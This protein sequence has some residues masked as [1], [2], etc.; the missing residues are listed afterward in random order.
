MKIALASDHAGFELKKGILRYFE[1][2]SV[3]I[4]DCG[5]YD[6]NPVDYVDT[7]VVACEK[8]VSGECQCAILICGTGHGMNMI[9]NKVKGIRAALCHNAEFAKL[10]REHNDANVLVLSGRYTNF[11]VAKEVIDSFLATN[12]SNEERHT[13]RINKITEYENRF[14]HRGEQSK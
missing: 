12:F 2:S 13:K 3:E 7:G 1:R 9:A 8:V 10:A 6:M 5:A 14:H 4:E 11:F